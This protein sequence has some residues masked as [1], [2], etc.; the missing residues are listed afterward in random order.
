MIEITKD[1][2]HK[3]LKKI[4]HKTEFNLGDNDGTLRYCGKSG[5]LKDYCFAKK[6]NEKY[7]ADKPLVES[8]NK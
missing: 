6:V 1:D 5:F 2:F 7:F 8:L 4:P 3:L